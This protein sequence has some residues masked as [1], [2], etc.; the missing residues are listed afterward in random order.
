MTIQVS[1]DGMREK[2][3]L[4]RGLGTWDKMMDTVQ[5]LYELDIKI[6]A[7]MV[8]DHTNYLDALS[9]L[10]IPYFQQI[11][12]V[13]IAYVGAASC[14]ET[15]S[16]VEGYEEFVCQLLREF[17]SDIGRARVQS[18]PNTFAVKYDGGVY[19]SPMASDYSLMCMGNINDE[20]I[21]N[22]CERYYVNDKL[23]QLTNLDI[24]SLA[25][26]NDCRVSD[27]CDRGSRLRA[28]KFFGDISAPD[29]FLCR[30]YLDEYKDIQIGKLFW[31][32]K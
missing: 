7:N 4:R 30:L 27:I 10:Q 17:E 8:L 28:L 22:I 9:V 13:P 1:I 11:S 6:T 21:S 12:F 19:I 20:N 5:K 3:E 14:G 18:F 25:H 26:C 23:E 31:G 24:S 15:N 32:I 16:S 2:H 29:P